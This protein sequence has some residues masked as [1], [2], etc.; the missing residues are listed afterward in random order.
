M[1]EVE[2]KGEKR[3]VE[4]KGATLGLRSFKLAAAPLCPRM[5]S[6]SSTVAAAAAGWD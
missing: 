5:V 1:N 4:V 3:D 6:A 2:S